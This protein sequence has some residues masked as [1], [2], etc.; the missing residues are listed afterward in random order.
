MSST[1]RRPFPD[2]PA[3]LPTGLSP[4]RT[5]HD[6]WWRFDRTDAR[7]WDWT[8]FPA[9]LHR[10][11]P[12]SGRFRVRYAATTLHGAVLER[13]GSYGRRR[14]TAADRDTTVARLTGDPAAVDVT[15]VDV[16]EALRVDERISVGRSVPTR[17]TTDDPLLDACGRLADRVDDWYGIPTT[18]IVFRSRH[19]ADRHN[20]AF[21]SATLTVDGV[22]ERLERD[23]EAITA[24]LAA[25][26]SVPDSWLDDLDP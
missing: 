2:L 8:P 4:T 23:R 15:D 21:S 25:G 14:V 18:T 13:F 9:P 11:D 3:R 10:F 22:P 7:I 24:L 5:G 6:R 17:P 26:V 20:L 1:T 12:P 19:D 16:R